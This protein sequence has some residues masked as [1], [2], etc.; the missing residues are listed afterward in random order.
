MADVY[1]MKVEQ[2]AEALQTDDVEQREAARSG[3]RALITKIVIPPE[4]GC[5]ECSEILGRCWRQQPADEMSQHWLVSLKV[6]AGDLNPRP[7]GY[8]ARRTAARYDLRPFLANTAI[9]QRAL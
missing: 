8:E 9:R 2:L 1:R 4:T 3:L 7:L 5:C 6:V